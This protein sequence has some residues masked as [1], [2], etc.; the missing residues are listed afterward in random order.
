VDA[1]LAERVWLDRLAR[2]LVHDPDAAADVAQQAWVKVLTRRPLMVRNVRAWLASVVR[3]CAVDRARSETRRGVREKAVPP[4]D[5]DDPTDVLLA[6][7]EAQR[8]VLDAVL[9]LDAPS[10]TVVLLRFFEGLE[11]AA[12]AL[13]TGE[14]AGTVRSRLHRALATL[15][16][17]LDATHGG[18]RAVWAVALVGDPLGYAASH[19]S[20]GKG[21]LAMNTG[22]KIGTGAVAALL[23]FLLLQGVLGDD[24]GEPAERP[25]VREVSESPR[26]A[27]VDAPAPDLAASDGAG[28]ANG[29]AASSTPAP[30]HVAV[31]VSEG[32]RRLAVTVLGP[33]A[34]EEPEVVEEEEPREPI[35]IRASDL[36]GQVQI[37]PAG[38]VE[39]GGGSMTLE[40]GNSKW[41][42]VPEKGTVTLRGRVVDRSGRPL[43]GAV[44]HRVEAE[45]GGIEGEVVSFCHI[46]EI[47]TAGDDGRFEVRGQPARPVRL[48]ADYARSMIR[49]RG[50]LLHQLVPVDPSENATI[51]SLRLSVPVDVDA[52]GSVAG[53]VVDDE[54]QPQRRV[55]VYAGHQE[56]RTGDDGTF[57][58]DTVPAGETT[59]QIE[60]YGW[61]VVQRPL[62]VV[63]GETTEAIVILKAAL[64]GD[65]LVSGVVRDRKGEPVA[66]VPLWCG[67][68]PLG[69]ARETVSGADGGFRFERLPRSL[70]GEDVVISVMTPPDEPGIRQATTTGIIVPSTD[71]VIVVDRGVELIVHLKDAVDAAPLSLYAIEVERLVDVDGEARWV[72]FHTASHYDEEGRFSTIVVPG[73]VR[74]H[75][76]APDHAPTYVEVHVPEEGAGPFEME[77]VLH[78]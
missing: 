15:R 52:F 3:S 69:F 10:R 11:P 45:A 46:H 16:Q 21:V 65:L 49:S 22:T 66:G 20:T 44:V 56:G 76:E 7:A 14:P 2:R 57:R 59:L 33:R 62:R 1:L 74:L 23:L 36:K 32:T 24:G 29:S 30:P 77:V 58:I 40:P 43:P 9:T 67:G 28:V 71:V 48:I 60:R 17:R 37:A 27:G 31:T 63:A 34:G 39:L 61:E 4:R 41:A 8:A 38:G 26:R 73:A 55:L 18:D 47:A 51:E 78:R 53:R 54:G 25:P 70:E 64:S 50:L 42:P 35:T 13:R 5:P 12:I 68:G 75:V 6:R 72:A 19:F